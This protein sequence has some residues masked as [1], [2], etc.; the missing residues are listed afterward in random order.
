MTTDCHVAI[1]GGGTG[2]LA[3]AWALGQAGLRVLLLERQSAIVA[4]RR[5]ELLQ[6][7]GLA[8]LDRLELLEPL[9]K[10]PCHRNHR[11]HFHRIGAGRLA[12][13]DYRELPPPFNYGLITLPQHLTGVLVERLERLSG[14]EIWTDTTMEQLLRDRAGRV[15]G[16]GA[17][18]GDHALQLAAR[19]VVGSDGAFSQVR[20]QAGL[21]AQVHVYPEAYLTL[22]VP[23]PPG[24][25]Y[26]ARY[27][28]GARE[29]LGLFPVTPDE[30]YLFYMIRTRDRAAVEAAGL[31]RLKRR[32][33]EIDPDLREPLAGVADWSAFGQMP[34]FR[35]RAPRWTADHVALIGDAAHAMNPHV[36]QGRN[37]ALE[38]ALALSEEI[39]RGL[40]HGD[41]TASRLGAY[42]RRRRRKVELLQRQAD[43]M[44]LFWNAGSWPLTWLRDRA[45]RTMERNPR[46]RRRSLELVT[47]L[48]EAP[49]GWLDKLVAAGF[50]PEAAARALGARD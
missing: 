2:G 24:F 1:V 6:P 12:T 45:F 11:F 17:R 36:A 15:V 5:G 29:I 14:V 9:L 20:Q 18:R 3:L 10:R 44:T 13:T 41:L 4:H 46:L 7:N 25:D 16:V 39:V 26:D 50:L 34:C 37:Q 43:E 30:L 35:V 8:V 21:G 19:V 40:E 22:L 23:R 33:V 38:D 49:L 42:E 47:G 48:A 32:L 28:V 27:Y 31:D